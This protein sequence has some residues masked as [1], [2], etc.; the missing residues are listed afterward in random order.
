MP[1]LRCKR[2]VHPESPE[3]LT[4]EFACTIKDG[5]CLRVNCHCKQCS[6]EPGIWCSECG[7]QVRHGVN[8]KAYQDYV[9]GRCEG[10]KREDRHV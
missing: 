1:C 7:R 2:E 8:S 10:K 9:C 6:A 4:K 5:L 3:A